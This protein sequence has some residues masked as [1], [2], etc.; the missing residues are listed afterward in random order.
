MI[1]VDAMATT[2]TWAGAA[3]DDHALSLTCDPTSLYVGLDISSAGHG[4]VKIEPATMKTVSP[5]GLWKG[6]CV[7][8]LFWDGSTGATGEDNALTLALSKPYLYAGLY[9]TPAKVIKLRWE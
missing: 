9:T 2:S 6:P 5:S 3:G 4:V 8:N 7:A 1:S